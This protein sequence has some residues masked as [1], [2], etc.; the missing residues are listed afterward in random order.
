[1]GLNTDMGSMTTQQASGGQGGGAETERGREKGE[2][3]WFF[4]KFF[5]LESFRIYRKVAR[6]ILEV[7]M[8]A[9]PGS[10]LTSYITTA[11]LSH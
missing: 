3:L 1:M 2:S 11:H 4:S 8:Q 5:I 7:P 6:I 10:L 9:S